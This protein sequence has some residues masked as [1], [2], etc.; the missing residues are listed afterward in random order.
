LDGWIFVDHDFCMKNLKEK[1]SPSISFSLGSNDPFSFSLGLCFG[2]AK[3]PFQLFEKGGACVPLFN[4][5]F[6]CGAQTCASPLLLFI[7][8]FFLSMADRAILP[9][10]IS[11]DFFYS[12]FLL[13]LMC[14][15]IYTHTFFCLFSPD[16]FH[17]V[18][19]FFCL[20]FG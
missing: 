18:G 6:S 12:F 3:W 17:F 11:F 9:S 8:F 10:L 4:F 7:Y 5:F 13:Q 15:Y 16:F 20:T 2:K 1:S 19:Q 14:I